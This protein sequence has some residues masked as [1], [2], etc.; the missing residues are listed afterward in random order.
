M[1][2]GNGLMAKAFESYSENKDVIIFASGVSNSSISAN[3][4]SFQREENLLS[5][6]L[7]FQDKKFIYFSTCS[8]S[9]NS[10]KTPYIEHKIRMENI[11]K[12]NHSNYLIFRLP[13]V[14]GHSDNKNTFFNNIKSKILL[15]QTITVFENLNR[16]IIDVDD[17]SNL[18]PI[19]INSDKN[20]VINVCLN[21]RQ[22]VSS[23]IRDM[24]EIMGLNCKKI[25]KNL[26]ET[27]SIVDNFYFISKLNSRNYNFDSDYN[28]KV[29]KK[30]LCELK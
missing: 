15:N 24:E 30:Y 14:I 27:N 6:Y 18:L 10:K 8:I 16:Y 21:N 11:I 9:D 4:I 19:F 1:V 2:I 22:L 28:K 20:K 3:E 26:Q 29:L 13:L 25:I 7:K 5:E 12:Q 17:L 23:I